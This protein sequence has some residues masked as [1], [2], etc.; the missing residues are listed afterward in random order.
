MKLVINYYDYSP[1]EL[2]VDKHEVRKNSIIKITWL[3]VIW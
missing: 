2:N 3:S 1:P